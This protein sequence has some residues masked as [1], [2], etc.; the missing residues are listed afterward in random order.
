MTQM[1]K[2]K[3]FQTFHSSTNQL[4]LFQTNPWIG[5]GSTLCVCHN[6]WFFN[7]LHLGQTTMAYGAGGTQ[8]SCVGRQ[9]KY[10]NCK[11]KT[12]WYKIQ[13]NVIN[14]FTHLS[15]VRLW[16]WFSLES[17]FSKTTIDYDFVALT[18]VCDIS[19]KCIRHTSV[20]IS[21]CSVVSTL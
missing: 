6:T 20:L 18:I 7:S 11:S 8:H 16:V 19:V 5:K 13:D 15:N 2:I 4:F 3:R 9:T 1:Y 14:F 21:S 17:I 10:N 12:E